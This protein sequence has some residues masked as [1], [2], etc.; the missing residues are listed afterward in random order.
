MQLSRSLI[1]EVR[2]APHGRAIHSGTK[3]KCRRMQGAS[4]LRGAA[5]QDMLAVS[6]SA[7]DP[8]PYQK[9]D[10][11][12]SVVQATQNGDCLDDPV[13]LHPS[14][15]GGILAQREMRPGSVVIVDIAL[16]DP[17]KLLFAGND[18][19]VEAT[20]GTQSNCE[21]ITVDAVPVPDQ[22]SR[23]LIPGEC[24]C[25]LTANPLCGRM[26]RD[27]ERDQL[28]TIMAKDNQAVEQL[29]ANRRNHEDVDRSSGRG[30]I[31]Q[32]GLPRL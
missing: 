15:E 12:I 8:C 31:S 23:L 5:E 27:A 10:P 9:L 19:V 1:L 6:F 24:L 7:H 13:A 17:A 14:G 21:D 22:I 28:P 18:D 16:H 26:S 30:V 29:E 32:E 25:D 2:L 11:T 3:R 20:H 4:G